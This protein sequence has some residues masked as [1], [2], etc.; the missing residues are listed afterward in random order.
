MITKRNLTGALA[1]LTLVCF[2][3][4]A[5]AQPLSESQTISGTSKVIAVDQKERLLTLQ[6]AAG[7]TVVVKVGEVARN[8]DQIKVGD[9]LNVTFT[10]ALTLSLGTPGATPGAAS[11]TKLTRAPVGS[12]PQGKVVNTLNATVLITAID[13]ANR[14]LTIKLPS[15]R[16]IVTKVAPEVTQFD[17][18]KVGDSVDAVYTEAMAISV[19][20]P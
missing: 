1:A 18:L 13:K 14:K 8:F 16:T 12:M 17:T 4:A 2:A 10:E 20:R 9:M 5:N 3:A 15:G 7:E 11:S 6:N 19:E